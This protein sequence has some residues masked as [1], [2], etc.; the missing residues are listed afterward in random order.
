MNNYNNENN[1]LI[2][3]AIYL[4]VNASIAPNLRESHGLST[5]E[6]S[7]SLASLVFHDH[8]LVVRAPWSR[9][10]CTGS[11]TTYWLYGLTNTR[12]CLVCRPLV[13][14]ACVACVASAS[15]TSH[16]VAF[17]R[18]SSP[19]RLS[20]GVYTRTLTARVS[21]S[22]ERRSP[23][24]SGRRGRLS[25]IVFTHTW[26]YIDLAPHALLSCSGV[27]PRM[28]RNVIK[29][30]RTH[31]PRCIGYPTIHRSAKEDARQPLSRT[32]LPA[33]VS[34]ELTKWS[35]HERYNEE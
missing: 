2:Q 19:S 26:A 30:G 7:P 9:T 16:C 24:D 28:H 27:Q 1:I 4:W 34:T 23:V 11:T 18:R 8:V 31:T 33:I 6:C 17:L 20:A 21:A 14:V 10:R 13:R 12:I 29:L 35:N 22:L 25:S 5:S 3:H 15:L 32:V